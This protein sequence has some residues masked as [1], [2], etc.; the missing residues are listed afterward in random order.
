M[1]TPETFQIPLETAELYEARFVP[2]LFADWAPHV[3][4]MGDVATG[5]SVLDVACGTGI[6]ARTAAARVGPAGHVV[7]V[8]LN[9]AMLTVAERVCPGIELRQADVT[10]LPF[11]AATFDVVLCQMALMFFP[12][13]QA[14]VREM[15]RV[16]TP[17]G[18]V[19][20]MVPSS[21]DAQPAYRPLV[22]LAARHAGPEAVAMLSAYWTCGDLDELLHTARSAGLDV[23]A[24]RTRM[25]T[26]RFASVD[27]FVAVEIEST[28]VRE[29]L[30]DDEYEALRREANGVLHEFV[31]ADGTAEIPLEGH[32]VAGRPR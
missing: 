10:D 31:T 25:G 20:I 5:Q 12:D 17:Q 28:P 6:V 22:E 32:L 15:R 13:P 11:D 29:R 3:V 2:A 8:D 16:V 9:D 21:L 7:G 24:T 30:T 18:T 4:D 1:T 26:A 14:A 19:V 23:L 27:E